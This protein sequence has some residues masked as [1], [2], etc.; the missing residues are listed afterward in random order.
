[1]CTEPIHQVI[2]T[3]PD[4]SL[5]LFA[6]SIGY[7]WQQEDVYRPNGYPFYQWMQ[8]DFGSGIIKVGTNELV[9]KSGEGCLI[10]ANTPHS[11]QSTNGTWVTS[12]FTFGGTFAKEI[13]T[14]MGFREFTY[15]E[16]PTKL[17]LDFAADSYYTIQN[18]IDHTG[19]NASASVYALLLALKPCLTKRISPTTSYIV[20]AILGLI[21]NHYNEKL[22]NQDFASVTHYSV[23]Y[24]LQTF[25]DVYHQTP[26]QYLNAHRIK[27]AKEL[28]ITAPNMMLAEVAYRNG[29]TTENYF[30]RIFKEEEHLTPGQF[31]AMF[32]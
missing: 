15:I 27:K 1:M 8:S 26:K 6:E 14:S 17:L 25:H 29:F 13:T 7:G 4:Y 11:Y 21:H 2:F 12:Y 20:E 16:H 31:R 32:C 10:A 23:Q 5:P 19:I 9:L 18:Q 22:T 24:S 28:L 30:I 3:S